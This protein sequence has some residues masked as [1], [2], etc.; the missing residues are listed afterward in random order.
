MWNY[1]MLNDNTLICWYNAFHRWMQLHS[2]LLLR[3]HFRLCS[4]KLSHVRFYKSRPTHNFALRQ[5]SG[6]QCCHSQKIENPRLSNKKPKK[7]Q[8]QISIRFQTISWKKS[9]FSWKKK[10][11][12]PKTNFLS[13]AK[14]S[15]DL[16]F[17]SRRLSF[18]NFSP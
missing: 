16:F 10:Q 3:G 9:H 2:Q 13:S 11:T 18:Q 1:I 12:S 7:T 17:F 4:Q 8:G 15:D 14:I 6:D 5:A